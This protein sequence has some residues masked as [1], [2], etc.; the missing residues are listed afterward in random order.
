VADGLRF[1]SSTQRSG[2]AWASCACPAHHY[3]RHASSTPIPRTFS[4]FQL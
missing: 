1:N 2:S 3:S 4:S